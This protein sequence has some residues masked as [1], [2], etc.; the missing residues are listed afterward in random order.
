MGC[1]KPFSVSGGMGAALLLAPDTAVAIVRHLAN[2][3]SVPVSVKIRLLPTAAAPAIAPSE[4]TDVGVCAK[5]VPPCL[6]L[7]Q[8]DPLLLGVDLEATCA[9][10]KR[11]VAAGAAAVSVHM[12]T[13]F[14]LNATSCTL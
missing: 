1:P 5:T 11:L 8:C 10:V 2:H 3:L 7:A 12:L 13:S 4:A 14:L 9:L 6:P